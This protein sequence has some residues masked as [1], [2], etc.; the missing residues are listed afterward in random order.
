MCVPAT[1][2]ITSAV[3]FMYAIRVQIAFHITLLNTTLNVFTSPFTSH[4]STPQHH[5]TTFQ[6]ALLHTACSM[7]HLM[8]Q[9]ITSDHHIL[10]PT[11]HRSL[12]PTA[13]SH[14]CISKH[15]IPH[16]TVHI[17]NYTTPHP[18]SASA[19]F[20]PH[21]V[22]HYTTTSDIT[23]HCSVFHI[24][25]HTTILQYIAYATVFTTT[26]P[27]HHISH[28]I[29]TVHILYYA[30][31]H[32][33]GHHIPHHTFCISVAFH[34]TPYQKFQHSTLHHISH[35]FIIHIKSLHH[36]SA[37]HSTSRPHSISHYAMHIA[38]FKYKFHI[39]LFNI[40]LQTT[41]HI[42]HC[43]FDHH[44]ASPCLISNMASNRFTRVFHNHI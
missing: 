12:P 11:L 25:H 39:T 19:Y 42:P 7:P 20:T 8:S 23:T 28:H 34:I 18:H 9:H 40:T 36:I 5:C 3:V 15:N 33:P 13:I 16:H 29:I 43:I 1:F 44:S 38:K 17:H 6:I 4:H 24:R 10:Y 14:H 31:V 22:P 35:N 26:I 37:H 21:R 41:P 30:T 32:I 2:H 27:Y